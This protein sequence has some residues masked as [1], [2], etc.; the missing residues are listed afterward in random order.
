MYAVSTAFILTRSKPDF[1]STYTSSPE[2]GY[3]QLANNPECNLHRTSTG[4]AEKAGRCASER[5]MTDWY[6]SGGVEKFM[7][8]EGQWMLRAAKH[9]SQF[10]R[11]LSRID[12]PELLLRRTEIITVE[13]EKYKEKTRKLEYSPEATGGATKCGSHSAPH[14]VRATGWLPVA[15]VARRNL[16]IVGRV[17]HICDIERTLWIHENVV[18][19]CISVYQ[20][21]DGT[22][23]EREWSGMPSNERVNI[24]DF[25]NSRP[26]MAARWG[27]VDGVHCGWVGGQILAV[28]CK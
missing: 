26:P 28:K 18:S 25:N 20:F 27:V 11:Q 24:V 13:T 17:A 9:A 2:Q 19:T 21:D 1:D 16:S 8:V 22:A 15:L 14:A 10:R 7:C 5:R 4:T 6:N 23:V 12:R 3:F